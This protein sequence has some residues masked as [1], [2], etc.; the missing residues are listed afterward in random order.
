M[1][2]NIIEFNENL[3]FLLRVYV[4]KNKNTFNEEKSLRDSKRLKIALT[5]RSSLVFEYMGPMLVKYSSMIHDEKWEELMKHD[6]LEEKKQV[7]DKAEVESYI[8]FIKQLYNM[9]N[10]KEKV[11][12]GEAIKNMLSSYCSYIIKLREKNQ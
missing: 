10:T 2:T 11:K 3:N 6:F 7:S 8:N 5:A 9:C 1:D 12:I 4:L